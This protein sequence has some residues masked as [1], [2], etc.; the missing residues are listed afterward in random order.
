MKGISLIKSKSK[1]K[2]LITGNETIEILDLGIHGYADSFFS[3]EEEA[4]ASF[5]LPLICRLDT[6]TGLIQTQVVT[7]PIERYSGVDYS[8]TSSNS[9]TAK[10]HWISFAEYIRQRRSARELRILEV[11]SNDGYLLSQFS[12]EASQIT[13]VDASPYMSNLATSQGIKTF[14]GIFGED[15]NLLEELFERSKSYDL[16]FANNVLNH[17]NNPVS[18]LKTVAKLLSKDGEFTF[19]V[20]YWLETI[21]S[22][23]FD[24]I[25]HEHVTYITV[26]SAEK[27]LEA[28]ELYI[29]NVE[30]VDYH[31]GSLRISA[32]HSKP[33]VIPSNLLLHKSREDAEDLRNP[34]RYKIYFREILKQKETFMNKLDEILLSEDSMVFGIG[35]A[36]KANTLLTFYGLNREKIDFILDASRYKQGKITPITRIPIYADSHL[37]SLPGGLGIILAWNIGDTIRKR[38]LEIN[39]KIEVIGI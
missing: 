2:S 11:G 30:V 26:T 1:T 33:T 27:L 29:S 9:E 25:Y 39:P 20:P 6:E 4:K 28:A 7:D 38:L 8:Y 13:G 16:I 5:G 15:E 23:H 17:S 34:L 36:A 18:F 19:E 21:K 10:Q 14:T 35:A 32:T 3:P 22:L 12:N 31:G 24:Q 37:K